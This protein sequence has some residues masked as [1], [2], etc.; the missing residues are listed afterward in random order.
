MCVF[1]ILFYVFVFQ[2]LEK[3]PVGQ[4]LYVGAMEACMRQVRHDN[5]DD[6]TVKEI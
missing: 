6:S 5:T 3:L 2:A 4:K 1:F